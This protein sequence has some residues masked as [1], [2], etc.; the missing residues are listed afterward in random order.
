MLIACLILHCSRCNSFEDAKLL[1][2][3]LRL[4][5]DFV[6]GVTHGLLMG[7]NDVWIQARSLFDELRRMDQPTSSAFYNALTDVLWHFGQVSLTLAVYLS[8]FN[9]RTRTH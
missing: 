1:L 9:V 6:Y 5:D 4:F 8:C 2:E 7:C 3:Q